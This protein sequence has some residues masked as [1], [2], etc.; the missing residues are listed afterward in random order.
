MS[1]IILP[2]LLGNL[3]NLRTKE[4]K[5]RADSCLLINSKEAL[6]E[7]MKFIHACMDMLI[8]M[9]DC[10]INLDGDKSIAIAGLRIRLFN[11]TASSLRLLLSGYYQ[12]T[13]SFIR[14]I[15][16]VSFL[17]DYFTLDDTS[18]QRWITKPEHKEFKP[19][20]IRCALDKRDGFLEQKRKDSYKLL[21]SYGTH[22][23]FDSY[24]LFNNNELLTIG[25]FF[26]Q[27]FIEN[28]LFELAVS[29]PH[30][31]LSCMKFESNLSIENLKT[32]KDFFIN[33]ESWWKVN[34][35]PNF[36]DDN[37][38]ELNYWFKLIETT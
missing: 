25:P 13:V 34:I 36:A 31:V 22:V 18:I 35:N 14:D 1:K 8:W 29:L 23:T 38:D 10:T 28:I 4:E 6:G 12:S 15:L 20:N 33:L 5:I 27:K 19:V 21:S 26:N 2:N 9:H 30:P 16:E 37:L 17:L 32:K 11:S 3:E 24:R 7:H